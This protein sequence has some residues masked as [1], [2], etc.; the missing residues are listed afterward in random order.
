MAGPLSGI[1]V[2]DVSAVISGPMCCQ[3]LADQGAEVIKVEPRG[4]GDLTRIGAFRV[5]TVSAMFAAAN[6]GKQSIAL[7]LSK[8]AGVDVF[9]E[10]A[11]DADVVVQNFRPGAVDRMGIGP[12]EL[13]R[14]NDRLIY[15]SISGFG[16]TGPYKDWRVYDPI[17]QSVAGL[18]SVQVHN[19]VQIPDLV[20]L[21]VCDKATATLAAQAVT[22][23]LF[24]RER[25]QAKGQHIEVPMLDSA[26]YWSWPDTFMAHSFYGKDVI[27]GPCV[28]S[29]YRLQQTADGY[30]VYF[31]ATDSEAFG[32]F[33][34]LGHPEWAEDP[35]FATPQS[36]QLTENFQA[37]GALIHEAFISFTTDEVL[38]K[39][40]A[41]QVPCAPVNSLDDVFDDPQVVH[42]DSIHTWTDP[43][44]GEIRQAR[45]P[46]RW[47]QTQH[48]PVWSV[49]ELGQSTEA[50]LRSHG[51]DDAALASL[52][53]ADVIA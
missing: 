44:I 29:I 31:T 28:Y 16:G 53:A 46:V 5:G 39:L 22:A 18:P 3:I 21:L 12:D 4:I 33:R 25:G 14:R 50:V 15:V 27:P 35:R 49:D 1:K 23:A 51:Y 11:A 30:L 43:R 38:P 47:Q 9:R 48:D 36:R 42:N 41:E 20:R 6:R 32:L 17:I 8:P 37:L 10:L 24:A 2:I 13:M 52:R 26:L 45:P 34:A 40:R 7:D 19:E